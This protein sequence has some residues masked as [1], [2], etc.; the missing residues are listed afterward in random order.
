MKWNFLLAVRHKSAAFFSVPT[1]AFIINLVIWDFQ[2][3]KWLTQRLN[4]NNQQKRK[5]RKLKTNRK[6]AVRWK[7]IHLLSEQL[8]KICKIIGS[9][10]MDLPYKRQKYMP[11]TYMQHQGC[12]RWVHVRKTDTQST[13]YN[14]KCS[15][16]IQP[17]TRKVY[18]FQILNFGSK[19]PHPLLISVKSLKWG[20]QNS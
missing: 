11:Y 12:R 1:M 17:A 14:S 5:K 16:M 18:I 8:T 19:N 13:V 4:P 3:I 10:I 9:S 20:N 2:F 6:K 15:T 7:I